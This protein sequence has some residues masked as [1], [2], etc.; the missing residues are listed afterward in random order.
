MGN[1][2][3][4]EGT[5]SKGGIR[6]SSIGSSLWGSNLKNMEKERLGAMFCSIALVDDL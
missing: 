2:P 5:G 6:A 3:S 1:S 4:M